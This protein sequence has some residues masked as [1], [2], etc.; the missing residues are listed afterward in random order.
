LLGDN[1][2][3]VSLRLH[4]V[5]CFFASGQVDEASWTRLYSA[6]LLPL[7]PDCLDPDDIESADLSLSCLGLIVQGLPRDSSLLLFRDLERHGFLEVVFGTWNVT[8]SS[9][10][11]SGNLLFTRRT[12]GH[13]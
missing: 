11:F 12:V 2:V 7:I 1:T 13:R 4:A 6:T 10:L 5:I 3:D 8:D 9:R